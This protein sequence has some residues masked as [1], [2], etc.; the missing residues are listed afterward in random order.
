LAYFILSCSNTTVEW[1]LILSTWEN[2]PTQNF[3]FLNCQLISIDRVSCSSLVSSKFI[4]SPSVLMT[5]FLCNT[6]YLHTN[7]FL[8]SSRKNWSF[9]Y[10]I[11]LNIET[12]WHVLLWVVQTQQLT[13]FKILSTWESKPT[14]NFN[15]LNCQLISIDRVSCSSLVSS[16]LINSPSVLMTLFHHYTRYFHTDCFLVSSRINW[17]FSYNFIWTLKLFSL[18]Y[19]ELFKHSNWMVSKYSLLKRTK[20]TR[21]RMYDWLEFFLG[22]GHQCFKPFFASAI[23]HWQN[24]LECLSLAK[25][26]VFQVRP[27]PVWVIFLGCK[28]L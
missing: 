5:L 23:T 12:I 15:F 11:H 19:F 7:C 17:S 24:K 13:G 9:S 8:L 14:Q 3:N 1:F 16:K 2:K 25:F 6:G 26:P 21:K 18:F 4:N 10:N 27:A 28:W 20:I 22:L